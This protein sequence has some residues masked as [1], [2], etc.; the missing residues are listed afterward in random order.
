MCLV[1][2][3]PEGH[4]GVAWAWLQ[5]LTRERSLEH[6]TVSSVRIPQI[7]RG[8]GLL[9]GAEFSVTRRVLAGK[10]TQALF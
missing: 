4:F 2:G 7:S 6:P 9:T 3:C 10:V 5:V 8:T 1:A